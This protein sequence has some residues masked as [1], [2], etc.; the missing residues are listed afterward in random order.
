MI[1][2][3]FSLR[4][5]RSEPLVEMIVALVPKDNAALPLATV[6]PL[7]LIALHLNAKWTIVT[8]TVTEGKWV[9]DLGLR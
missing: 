5:S 8:A 3:Q 4:D 2:L 7:R 6:A 9:S 1:M